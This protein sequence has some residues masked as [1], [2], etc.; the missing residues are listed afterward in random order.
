MSIGRKDKVIRNFDRHAHS[1][2]SNAALQDSVAEHLI[3]R[4]PD[5][6]KENPQILEIGCGTGLL[7]RRLLQKYPHAQFHITDMSEEMLRRTRNKY[8]CDRARFFIMDGEHPDCDD[9][10][11]LIVSAMTFHWFDDPLMAIKKLSALGPIYYSVPG[12]HN[13][14]EWQET[15]G[16]KNALPDVQWPG[17]M[18]EDTIE[19]DYGSAKGFMRMLKETGTSIPSN[20]Y[21]HL[22]A[23]SLKQSLNRHEQTY[24]GKTT[25]H[26]LYGH[27]TNL[28]FDSNQHDLFLE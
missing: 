12:P 6:N 20:N 16:G 5:L 7:T 27:T 18:H 22:E 13:F 14:Q 26:I 24:A 2:E 19:K 25:W 9:Q 17:I 23:A 28:A 10:Y 3:S 21:R 4:L 8:A 15:T 11:D 1:Y